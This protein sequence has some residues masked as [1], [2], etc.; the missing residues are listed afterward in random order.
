MAAT[1][2]AVVANVL[3]AGLLFWFATPITRLL[4]SAGSKTLSKIASLLLAAIA[5]MM[6]R[7]GLV[8]V[9]LQVQG[10]A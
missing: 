9:F 4:G 7:K 6:V 2:G 3:I 10:G 5:V 1:M 8:A